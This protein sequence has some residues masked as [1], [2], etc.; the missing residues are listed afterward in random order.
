M[1]FHCGN[2]KLNAYL[3]ATRSSA[4]CLPVQ[5]SGLGTSVD[6]SLLEMAELSAEVS[7]TKG[8]DEVAHCVTTPPRDS[9]AFLVTNLSRPIVHVLDY[10]FV[11]TKT[12]KSFSGQLES[13]QIN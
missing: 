5:W 1:Q 3:L 10:M 12:L 13:S 4:F 6:V 7:P 9:T 8:N 2:Q 11:S